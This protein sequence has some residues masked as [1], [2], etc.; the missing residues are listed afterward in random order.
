MHSVFPTGFR[1]FRIAVRRC[2]VAKKSRNARYLMVKVELKCKSVTLLA[3]HLDSS[4]EFSSDFTSIANF[5]LI[6][7]SS[8]SVSEFYCN[9]I[10]PK[11]SAC[12][13]SR[14]ALYC[15]FKL[16]YFTFQFCATHFVTFGWFSLSLSLSIIY[17]LC[18]LMRWVSFG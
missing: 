7:S 5:L 6:F 14:Y 15:L 9:A 12:T 17:V 10:I 1:S 13:A 18:A 11:C 2:R 4:I 8:L 16:L 3:M